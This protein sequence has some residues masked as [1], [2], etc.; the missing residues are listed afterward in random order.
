MAAGPVLGLVESVIRGVEGRVRSLAKRIAGE[1]FA[2]AGF[3]DGSYVMDERRGTTVLA[4]A[5]PRPPPRRMGGE[6]A[7][8]TRPKGNPRPSGRGGGQQQ[9]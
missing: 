4:R 1:P 5:V 3:V 9:G 2:R 8:M 7:P 6:R